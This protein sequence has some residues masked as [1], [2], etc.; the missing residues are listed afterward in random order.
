MLSARLVK[1]AA[2]LANRR[3]FS[4][5]SGLAAIDAEVSQL[6]AQLKDFARAQAEYVAAS[7]ITVQPVK[8]D[9]KNVSAIPIAVSV[10]SVIVAEKRRWR[11]PLLCCISGTVCWRL[12][13][14]ASSCL[15]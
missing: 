6:S 7:Q 10:G 11:S 2:R 12:P 4:A 15:F 1:G 5:P 13:P 8:V 9:L 14:P 3:F